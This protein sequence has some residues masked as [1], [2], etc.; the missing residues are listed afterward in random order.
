MCSRQAP[1]RLV[2]VF[3]YCFYTLDPHAAVTGHLGH[4]WLRQAH[5]HA[6]VVMLVVACLMIKF[7]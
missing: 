2:S 4:D 6:Y 7:N 1:V 5:K 3:F